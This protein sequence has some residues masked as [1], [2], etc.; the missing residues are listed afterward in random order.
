MSLLKGRKQQKKAAQQ[1]QPKPRG[2]HL[3]N[4]RDDNCCVDCI[5]TNV[6]QIQRHTSV[7]VFGGE[8]L[9]RVTRRFQRR[10][11]WACAEHEMPFELLNGI[12]KGQSNGSRHQWLGARDTLLVFGFS[13]VTV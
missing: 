13:G 2:Q 8:T 7:Q 4:W 3:P 6:Q 1:A 10:D 11:L 9:R 12:Y 5:I